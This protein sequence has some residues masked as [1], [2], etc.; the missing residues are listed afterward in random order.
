[1]LAGAAQTAQTGLLPEPPTVFTWVRW[2]NT[3]GARCWRID[4][5]LKHPPTVRLYEADS[6]KSITNNQSLKERGW[7]ADDEKFLTPPSKEGGQILRIEVTGLPAGRHDVYARF[8]SRPRK[9][10]EN[11][12]YEA[13]VNL[14]TG[15]GNN[16][17]SAYMRTHLT[18]YPNPV[19]GVR[20][21]GGKGGY[22]PDT[23]YEIK[24]GTIGTETEPATT[25]SL[26]VRRMQ[27]SEFAKFGDIRIETAPNIHYSRTR[28]DTPEN[29]RMR[30]CFARNA[31]GSFGWKTVSGMVKVRPK[32]FDGLS[33]QAL[34]DSID[35]T[36]ARGEYDRGV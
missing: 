9:P 15:E 31:T 8:F 3:T 27:W 35:L 10:G 34:G 29:R 7:F 18:G 20:L 32:S 6:G 12:W 1:M 16:P 28:E 5:D 4:S 2:D 26:W 36:A 33:G 11:W 22:D 25:A 19:N 14:G 21:I 13:E 17:P 30:E 24:L 23:L